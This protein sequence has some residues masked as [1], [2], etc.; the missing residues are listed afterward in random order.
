[1]FYC[2]MFVLSLSFSIFRLFE[3]GVNEIYS[4]F[5]RSFP[6]N[7]YD[8]RYCN[9]KVPKNCSLFWI[10]NLVNNFF[11]NVM[12]LMLSVIIDVLMI[13]F[14]NRIIKEKRALNCPHLKEAIKFKAK[15]NK[16]IITNGMLFFVS[17]IP[18]F[19][20]TLL[21]IIFQKLLAEFSF[22]GFSFSELIE[23]AQTFHFI[24]IQFQ[25]FIFLKFDRNFFNSCR[26]LILKKQ[27]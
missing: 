10:L 24:S 17:H 27:K 18:E 5:D 13:R 25:F 20:V 3:N 12:F 14:S 26:D 4:N 2:I 23:I 22:T 1:M 9:L 8:L 19:V 6:Y 15:L 11:N 16:M 21:V 7:A